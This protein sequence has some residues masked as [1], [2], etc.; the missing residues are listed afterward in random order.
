MIWC[1]GFTDGLFLIECTGAVFSASVV[2]VDTLIESV[3]D[4]P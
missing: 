2:G 3:T 4:D 1:T